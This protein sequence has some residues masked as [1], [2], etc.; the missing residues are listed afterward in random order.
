[1]EMFFSHSLFQSDVSIFMHTTSRYSMQELTLLQENQ[2]LRIAVKEND[3]HHDLAITYFP[4][5]TLVR[6]PQLSH[7]SE[8]MDVVASGRADMTFWNEDLF[9]M[10]I[11]QKKLD[12]SLFIKKDRNG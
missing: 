11:Q 1:M 3:V 4:H 10:Y 9:L 5:A 2:K 6:V 7:I 8:I 12:K